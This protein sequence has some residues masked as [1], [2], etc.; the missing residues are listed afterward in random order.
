MSL[1]DVP[2]GEP[3]AFN[4]VV[5]I[6]QDSQDKYEYDEELDVIKLDRVLYGAQF[7]P[8]N[9]GFIPQTRAEDGDHSDA[10]VFST[11]PLIC[12][13]VVTVKAI[14]MMDM[15]DSGEVDNKILC[16]PVKD[17]RFKDINSLEDISS[18]V[19]AEIK[20]FFETY[21]E[22]QGKKVEIKGF[23]DKKAALAELENTRSVYGKK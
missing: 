21:K 11:N 14:G 18:H 16:V 3:E 23:G 19:L 5:E 9:Y 22:L 1:K 7:Y 8:V 10:L 12:G 4:V 15:V 20:N 13:S 6:S 17:P 2:F